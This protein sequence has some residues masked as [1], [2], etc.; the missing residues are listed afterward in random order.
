MN[1]PAGGRRRRL[2]KILSI[3]LSRLWRLTDRT[4]WHDVIN[5]VADAAMIRWDQWI[6]T[7]MSAPSARAY[8]AGITKAE[9]AP[10]VVVLTLAGAF[11]LMLE[12]GWHY[13][14]GINLRVTLLRP[15][16]PGVKVSKDGHRYRR[17]M[18]RHG[19]QGASGGGAGYAGEDVGGA[20][21]RILGF[22]AQQSAAR[23]ALI[24]DAA[25][26]LRPYSGR[27]KYGRK[28]AGGSG[29]RWLRAGLVSKLRDRHVT[30]IYAGMRR[31]SAAAGGGMRTWRT[32]T[33]N[34]DARRSDAAGLNWH[35]PGIRPRKLIPK[36]R[37]YIRQ[38]LPAMLAA[39]R[40]GGG[41][42]GP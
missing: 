31:M 14:G 24:A 12:R 19:T 26:K 28:P 29:D 27:G 21:R 16:A 37:D 34:P 7:S 2:V 3:D 22:N 30:D 38:I 18:F 20:E 10:G 41:G 9:P 40:A 11:P 36:V 42:G 33:S 4:L 15:G 6:V 13:P 25:K 1:P 17:V 39:A 35:H 8:R 32:I 23:A 5:D